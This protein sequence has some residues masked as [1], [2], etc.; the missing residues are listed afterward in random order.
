MQ[1]AWI[2]RGILSIRSDLPFPECDADKALV[3]V[4]IAGICGTDLQLLQGYK[5]F[6]GIPGHEFIGEV[7]QCPGDPSW[8]GKR[9]VSDINISCGVCPACSTGMTTHC[10]RR[11]IVGIHDQ[12]G[13]FAQYLVLPIKN[14][15]SVPEPLSD[16]S[17]VFAEPSAA[18]L[19]ILQQ[20]NI[21][22]D[23]SVL[24]VGAGR[25]G[26][27]IAQ[28]LACAGCKLSAIVRRPAQTKLLSRYNIRC[29][30]AQQLEP[31]SFDIV[32]EASGQAEGLKTGFKALRPRGTLVL[33]STYKP[34]TEV[35]L[36]QVVINEFTVIGSRCGPM[37][38]A[39]R[40]LSEGKIQPQPL[41]TARYPLSEVVKAFEHAA[42]PGSLKTIL[43]M[44]P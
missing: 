31:K 28:V 27:L 19:E 21:H 20:V 34:S 24:L 29:L 4:R 8:L 22:T 33:K 25:L 26:Q 11:S 32:I 30:E 1:G 13:A 36:S 10:H 35:D 14:L 42:E 5:D 43:E 18:A 40:Y 23:Q 6:H 15:H 9:V 38:L 12:D 7:I 16:D 3:K 44:E 2:E 41:I 17:A 37:D 39:L